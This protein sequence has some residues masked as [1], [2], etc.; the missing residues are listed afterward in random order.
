[1]M[2]TTTSTGFPRCG[3]CMWW[4]RYDKSKSIGV[5]SKRNEYRD[6]RQLVDPDDCYTEKGAT[7]E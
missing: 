4:K 1:M 2:D 3:M 7:H 6:E 5:C